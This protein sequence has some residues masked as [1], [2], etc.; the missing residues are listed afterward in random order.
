VPLVD[1]I[2]VHGLGGTSRATWSKNRDP[3]MFWPQEWLPMEPDIQLAR[4]ISFG[5]NAHFAAAGPAPISDISDFAKDLLY[6]MKFSK[7]ED[8]EDLDIGKVCFLEYTS[9]TS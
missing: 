7:T 9:H 2:L 4:I 6:G 5:Y 8:A 3:A 1:I